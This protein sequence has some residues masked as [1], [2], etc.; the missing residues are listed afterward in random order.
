MNIIDG[1]KSVAGKVVKRVADRRKAIEQEQADYDLLQF[2]QRQLE[3]DRRVKKPFDAWMDKWNSEY[4]A[5][6]SFDNLS[7]IAADDKTPRTIVNFPRMIIESQ[8]DSAVPD[9]DFKAVAKDDEMPVAALKNYCMYVVRVATP[10]LSEINLE[11][12]R[13]TMKYGVSFIKV[14]W[15]NAIKKAGY[16]GDIELS[17]PHPKDII[18]NHGA[19]DVN[20]MEHYH[21]VT[22]RHVKYILRKWRHLTKQDVEDKAVLY[23]EFDE[24]AGNQRINVTDQES[25]DKDANLNK[26]TV[27]E[28]TYR[29]EDG[30]IC[31]LWWSGDLLIKHIPKFFYRRDEK[32][33][34]VASEVLEEDLL[35]RAGIN[36]QTGESVTKIVPAGT[37]VEYYIPNN[38]DLV[39]IP[40]IP[41]DKCWW[42]VSMME[43]IH[44][45]NESIKKILYTIEESYLRG[46]KKILCESDDIKQKLLDPFSEIIVVGNPQAVQAVELGP[47]TDGLILMDK[48]KE[49]L[50]LITGATNA[51]L[52]MRTPG[53]TSGKQ[54]LVY[55]E[56]AAQKISL[57]GVYKAAAYK[58]LYRTIA[59]FAM[60]FCDDDRPFRLAGDREEEIYGSFN[61]L[62]LLKD[63]NGNIVFPD[64]DIETTAEP[65]FMKAKGE[66]FSNLVLLAGQGRFESTPSNLFLIKVLDKLGV[67]H[68]KDLIASMSA[69]VEQQKVMAQQRQQTQS[70]QSPSGQQQL[71]QGPL[72]QPTQGQ[73]G[74]QPQLDPAIVQALQQNPALM[75]ALQAMPTDALTEFFS[76]TL[77]QQTQMLV[78]LQQSLQGGQGGVV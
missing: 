24:M 10:S 27:I 50:Q 68:L 58:R 18:P 33:N 59:D 3:A 20:D 25:G 63:L 9:P 42:P 30:D 47:G 78:Q 52:G 67:P 53:S 64:L 7:D 44:D 29:D 45:L 1:L 37:E 74:G 14:H 54:E 73:P 70:Q 43:D 28:T 55:V 16:I 62:N 23:R 40:F 48:M 12:E 5:G 19:K 22:N 38:W 46:R 72:E 6:R 41:R 21:H 36:S 57:K 77:E 26:Y 32:G 13:R 34:P 71:L 35:V 31:K 2:W 60:A 8:I 49:Y 66:V 51:A 39:A 75:Q 76:A 65:A 11:N 17:N 69:E 61:R 15:N 56:Q 4:E